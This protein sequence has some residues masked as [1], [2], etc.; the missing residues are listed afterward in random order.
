MTVSKALETNYIVTWLIAREDF[1][2]FSLRDSFKPYNVSGS[3][4]PLSRSA[5]PAT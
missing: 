5:K 4:K 1:T 2:A 3:D